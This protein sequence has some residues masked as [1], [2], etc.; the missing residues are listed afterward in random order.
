MAF[1]G[2]TADA[3]IVIN[4]AYIECQ[5][6]WLTVQ[7]PVTVEYITCS[8]TGLKQ[9]HTRAVST[10]HLT[11]LPPPDY[12]PEPLGTYHAWKANAIGWSTKSVHEFLEESY[13]DDETDYLTIKLV[14]KALLAVVQSGGKNT[15]LAVLRQNHPLNILNPEEFEKFVRV[16]QQQQQQAQKQMQ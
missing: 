5:S 12:Q 4:R 13:T 7:D 11:S 6:H 16:E 2:L 3:R 14:T 8:I 10:G 1:A 9:H 15:E